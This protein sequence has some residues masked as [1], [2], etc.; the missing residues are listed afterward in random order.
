MLFK[1][2]KVKP[3]HV[4]PVMLNGVPLRVVEKFKYLGQNITT[5]DL[6][7]DQDIERERSALAVC[8]NMLACRFARCSAEV[9][10]HLF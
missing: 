2:E 8:G 3:Y 7:D 9:K 4:P 10:M 1:A 5:D 6:N